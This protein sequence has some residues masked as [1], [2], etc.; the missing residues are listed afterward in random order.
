MCQ[1]GL[2]LNI[3]AYLSPPLV[4]HFRHVAGSEHSVEFAASW[5][6]LHEGIR[7]RVVDVVV[8]DPAADGTIRLEEIQTLVTLYP[9]QAKV[10]Y[11]A[12]TPPSLKAVVELAR[13]GL[14]QVV[15]HR[16]DDDAVRF[17][18]L[19]SRQIGGANADLMLAELA[20][21]L[22]QL[23]TPLARAVR[24]LFQ[25]PHRFWNAQDL[26]IAAGMARRTM[27]RELEAAGFASP[28]LLVQAARVLRAFSYLRE[29]GHRVS[30]V[31]E[32]LG[33]PSSR[34]LLKH[35]RELTGSLPS[36]LRDGIDDGE[37]VARLLMSLR[38]EGAVQPTRT[39]RK[40]VVQPPTDLGAPASADED[41]A[42][43][44]TEAQDRR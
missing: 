12:L 10:L 22:S 11:L 2:K 38:G 4:G 26:A 21:Q 44:G 19:L 5:E 28:R 34:G 40:R 35:A 39:V 7:R 36:E 42:E 14:T 32:K 33:Y 1:P 24:M 3:L 43:P 20:G 18:A 13:H 41:R 6:S 23:S 17:R 37:L 16:F 27:Y 29:P 31:A 8:L 9:M 30:D 25:N 15:L